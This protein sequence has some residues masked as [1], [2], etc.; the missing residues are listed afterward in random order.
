MVRGQVGAGAGGSGGLFVV[1]RPLFRETGRG[2]ESVCALRSLGRAGSGPPAFLPASRTLVPMVLATAFWPPGV[3]LSRAARTCACF[4][5]LVFTGLLCAISV[6]KN[7][8]GLL[9]Q[10]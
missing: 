5:T 4:A 8:E 10:R 2:W 3:T 9:H 7:L 6:I 1:A